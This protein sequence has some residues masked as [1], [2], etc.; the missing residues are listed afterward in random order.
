MTL[1]NDFVQRKGK[2]HLVIKMVN[3][4]FDMGNLSTRLESR[5]LNPTITGLMSKAVNTQ[6][7]SFYKGIRAEYEAYASGISHSIF[8]LIV[9]KMPLQ[10]LFPQ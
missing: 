8:S 4:T 9:D 10:D 7:R 5:A 1:T 3:A 6:W 2:T